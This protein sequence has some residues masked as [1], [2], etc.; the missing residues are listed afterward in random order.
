MNNDACLAY[1]RAGTNEVC[2]PTKKLVAKGKESILM[3]CETT[4][5]TLVRSL[6]QNLFEVWFFFFI[7]TP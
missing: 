7:L 5:P 6:M 2:S 4:L 3:K 1:V